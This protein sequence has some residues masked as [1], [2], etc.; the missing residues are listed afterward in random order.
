MLARVTSRLLRV[1]RPRRGGRLPLILLAL[2]V[3]AGVTAAVTDASASSGGLRFAQLGHW[4]AQ[5][6]EN[7]VF[8][9]NGNG[10]VDAKFRA[11]GMDSEDTQVVQGDTAG[12]VLGGNR[13]VRFGKSTL[14][15]EEGYKLQ[16]PANGEEPVALE[17]KGGP[18]YVYPEQ[19]RIVRFGGDDPVTIPAGPGGPLGTPVVTPDGTLWLQHRDSNGLCLLTPE[20]EQVDCRASAPAGHAGSLTV[21]GKQA[22]FVD[23]DADTFTPVDGNGLGRPVRIGRDLPA[24]AKI[25]TADMSGR[26]AV[27]DPGASQMHIVD[28]T[29]L[30]QG[31]VSADISVT[32]PPGKYETPVAG[33]DAVV[34]LDNQGKSVRTFD[35][36]GRQQREGLLPKDKQTTRLS[37]GEDQRVYVEGS[38]GDQVYVVGDRGRLDKV[39][40]PAPAGKDD[41]R[42][43][44]PPGETTPPANPGPTVNGP[45]QQSANRPRNQGTTTTPP[46]RPTGRT[47][48]QAPADPPPNRPTPQRTTTTNPPS[49]PGLP[50]GLRATVSGGN[51]RVSWGAAKENGSAVTGYRVTWSGGS[52]GSRTVGRNTRSTTL[53]GLTR[54]K[55]YKITVAAQNAAG[56]GTAAS[57]RVLLPAAATSR[58]VRVSRGGGTT[59]SPDCNRPDCAWIKT[60]IRGFPPNSSMDIDIYSSRWGRF[61][62]VKL[63]TNEKGYLMV[64]DRFAYNGSGGTIWATVNGVSSNRLS[65]W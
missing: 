55:N 50:P 11:E 33:R 49:P 1:L 35:R 18:Y 54:A 22:V 27:L 20:A 4:I 59:H 31:R 38:Q 24:D 14:E 5:P 65:S 12:Y 37:R 52:S 36:D 17:A 2:V 47:Q 29:G 56:R 15:V 21:V 45:T 48:N 51:I 10:A 26:V 42:P 8:H 34:L 30:G 60:E 63:T 62:G 9:V 46:N 40:P 58:S 44:P 61:N 13:A 16:A 57:T 6:K 23:T 7:T 32:L 39:T 19:G 25:A 43:V 64:D 3:A 28:A 41:R 53:S